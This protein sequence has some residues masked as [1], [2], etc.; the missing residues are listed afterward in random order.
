MLSVF[1]D[2]A[3]ALDDPGVSHTIEGSCS[4]AGLTVAAEEYSFLG[5]VRY[6][7]ILIET[8]AG[9]VLEGTVRVEAQVDCVRCLEPFVTTLEGSLEGLF[10]RE[11]KE[12]GIP[13]EQDFVLVSGETVD[14]GSLVEVA[15]TLAAPF[16]PVHTED[17]RGIC[18]ECGTDRNEAMCSCEPEPD[19]RWAS[20]RELLT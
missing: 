14:I 9:I 12:E 10:V 13:A 17:C 16:A 5:P 15:L 2:L 18:P 11:G 4:M 19:P 3:R 20:L 8:G 7:A 6:E 1:V